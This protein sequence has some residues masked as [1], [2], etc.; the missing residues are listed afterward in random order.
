[1]NNRNRTLFRAIVF[2]VIAGA[3]AM[4]AFFI[5][6]GIIH[7]AKL[8][9][10]NTTLDDYLSYGILANLLALGIINLC[11][12]YKKI[13]SI[14]IAGVLTV[15]LIA[16]S[17]A[18]VVLGFRNKSSMVEKYQYVFENQD[19]LRLGLQIQN[20]YNCCGWENS[21]DVPEEISC[22]GSVTCKSSIS[23]S[24]TKILIIVVIGC[25][26]S[27][28]LFGVGLYFTYKQFNDVLHPVAAFDELTL[29]PLD[30]R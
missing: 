7:N 4:F 27:V 29:A 18:T 22:T 19:Y 5:A 25:I 24:M 30:G 14:A 13:V 21:T 6:E 20:H 3:M 1:M 17:L 2:D 11:L 23:S 16:F 15:C 10:I 8:S 12:F 9:G 26:I 28:A